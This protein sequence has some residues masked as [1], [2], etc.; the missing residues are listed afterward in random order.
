MAAGCL[1]HLRVVSDTQNDPHDHPREE[2]QRDATMHA[3]IHSSL[4]NHDGSGWGRCTG[5]DDNDVGGLLLLLH[6]HHGWGVSLLLG[7]RPWAWVG[8]WLLLHRA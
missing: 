6:R 2:E 7:D 4:V 3:M 5:I 1:V 8:W